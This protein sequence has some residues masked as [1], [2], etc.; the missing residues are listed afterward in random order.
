MGEIISIIVPV[1][2]VE[3]YL[4][5]CL[6]SIIA[7]S[8]ENIEI[9]LVDD[10][11]KDNSGQICDAYAKKDLRI[12]VIH[13]KNG[14]LSDA[15]NEGL[16]YATGNFIIFVDSDDVISD[17]LVKYLYGLIIDTGADIGI[18]DPV[19]C[20][21]GHT[22]EFQ[23]EQCR[24][25]FNSEDAQLEML[26][27]RSFLVAAWGKIYKRKCFENIKFPVGM[28]FEDSAVMYKIFDKVEKIV[29]GDAKLYGY[30]HREGS[31]TTKKF[32]KKDCDILIISQE[33]VNFY[34][35][36]S[37][38]LQQAAR[39]YQTAAA[40][41]IYMNAPRNAEFCS[42]LIE[43]EKILKE[44]QKSVFYD[45][46]VRKKMKMAILLYMYARPIMPLVYRRVNRWK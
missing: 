2:N 12:K 39:S 7:Q 45:K 25:I 20:Y 38:E 16:K 8:Y 9:I 43:C 31:I 4:E 34:K 30:M 44:N 3:D 46:N 5:T 35:V 27:Q 14:G 15:R 19:H 32:S 18:C 17:D 6:K 37:Q 23:L 1:Y 41:R 28:L 10:G 33:I 40:F 24:K 36:K 42:E 29:Y 11:S 22:I 13:K 21:P 26:Y